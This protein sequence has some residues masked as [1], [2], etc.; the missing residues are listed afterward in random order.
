VKSG[1]H[2]STI[3]SFVMRKHSPP[4]SPQLA[5]GFVPQGDPA[6]IVAF[7]DPM[8][9][10]KPLLATGASL[11]DAIALMAEVDLA[12]ARSGMLSFM[13]EFREKHGQFRWDGYEFKMISITL[14]WPMAYQ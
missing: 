2:W 8:A 7:E 12:F 14:Q 1:F 4:N 3:I 6:I 5:Q 13:E 10:L 9:T 11:P